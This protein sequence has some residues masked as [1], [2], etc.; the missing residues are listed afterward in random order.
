[1]ET[2][3]TEVDAKV[4]EVLEKVGSDFTP[5]AEKDKGLNKKKPEAVVSMKEQAE[6]R[7]ADYKPKKSIV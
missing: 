2:F 4:N 1:M 6:A 3:K 7:K 5:K